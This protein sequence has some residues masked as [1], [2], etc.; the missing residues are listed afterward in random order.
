MAPPQAT[1]SK[2][3]MLILFCKIFNR[4]AGAGSRAGHQGTNRPMMARRPV[5][6]I[7]RVLGCEAAS[8]VCGLPGVFQI[9]KPVSTPPASGLR[10]LLALDQ[11]PVRIS[12][13]QMMVKE[14]I[15]GD[16]GFV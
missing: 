11:L 2:I 6:C 4:P 3:N 12:N 7:L 13:Y 8:A 14:W 15:T 16:L 1:Q 9:L 5:Y 10:F